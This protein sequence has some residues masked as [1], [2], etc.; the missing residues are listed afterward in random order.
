MKTMETNSMTSAILDAARETLALDVWPVPIKTGT[1]RPPMT[2]WQN[3]RLTVDDLAEFFSNGNNGLGWLLGISPRPIA[4]IDVDSPEALA[5]ARLIKGPQTDRVFGRRS[6]P[7]AHHLYELTEEF[8]RV[9]FEDPVMK[10]NNPHAKA[11]LVELRGRGGQTIVPPSLH[12]SGEQREWE[13]RGEFGKTT[14]TELRAWVA[15]VASAALL[16]RYWP[17]GYETRHAMAGM[18][19]RAG[20]TEEAT[21][22]FVRAILHV[23]QPDN[24]EARADVRNTF[25]KMERNDEFIGRPKLEELLGENGK[26]IVGAAAEWLGIERQDEAFPA[27]DGENADRFA[28]QHARDLR[29]CSEQNVW[30]AWDGRRWQR[31]ARGEVMRRARE[32]AASIY[33]DAWNTKDPENKKRRIKWSIHADSRGGLEAMIALARWNSA[34]EVTRFD[35]TFDVDPMLFNCKNGIVNLSTG[36]IGPHRR[37]TMMTK[38]S[39]V[40]Y[41]PKCST[42]KFAAFVAQTFNGDYEIAQF[43]KR[44]GGY[45]L[46]G[47][48]AEIAFFIVYGE[49]GTAK[50]TWVRLLQALLGDY[51]VAIPGRVLLAKAPGQKDYDTCALAGA[52]LATT[53]ETRAGRKLDE[54]TVKGITG[55]DILHGERKYENA[56]T[57]RSKAKLLLA[58][59]HRPA[60]RD[61]DDAIWKR[62]KPIEFIAKVPSEKV[63]DKIEEK[64]IAEEGPGILA[65]FVEGCVDWKKTGLAYP[66]KVIEGARNYRNEQDEVRCFVEECCVVVEKDA[67]NFKETKTASRELY[68]GYAAWVKESGGR[69]PAVSKTGFGKELGRLGCEP[70]RTGGVSRWFGIRL[71]GIGEET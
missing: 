56:F 60:V 31:D 46:T 69:R 50:S 64:L 11:M 26:L 54:E 59:N 30:Y 41:D 33:R 18:L 22:E 49:T 2:G 1:K 27:T 40:S 4:D 43:M 5:V 6:T 38:L 34:I 66:E 55:Q 19:A 17:R 14:F 52:R 71:R 51:A 45:F 68:K 15:K 8:D 7:G 47:E 70:D 32:T 44:L 10:K 3:L 48:T 21:T 35:G 16:V 12:E 42:T 65:W 24:H 57:F 25:A 58:T 20:W 53:V 37:E 62:I 61:T 39:P 36:E 67:V 23:A 28:E 63:V 9:L 29:Y 13:R